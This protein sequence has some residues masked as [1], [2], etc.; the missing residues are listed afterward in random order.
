MNSILYN[1]FLILHIT[2]IT[3]MAGATLIDYLGFKHFWKTFSTDL[4]K[5]MVQEQAISKL[6]KLM[7]FGMLLI[8]ISGIG[9]MFFMHTVYGQQTWMKIKIFLVLII[10][11]NG[12]GIRRRLGSRLTKLLT[13]INPV[14][15][16]NEGIPKLRSKLNAVGIIQLFLFLIVFI[17]SVFK[18]N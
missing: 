12:L 15:K 14:E 5:A 2:G 7:G 9:M 1:L 11:I 18:F 8:L 6:Q 13:E 4:T 10:I 16:I 3:T 17:L